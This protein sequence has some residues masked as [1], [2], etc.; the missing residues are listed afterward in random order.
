[1]LYKKM[2]T[3]IKIDTEFKRT[4]HFEYEQELE[5]IRML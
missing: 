5:N 1:M 3:V 2:A 4:T